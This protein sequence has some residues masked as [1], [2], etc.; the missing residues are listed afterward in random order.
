M[1]GSMTR[2]QVVKLI[3]ERWCKARGHEPVARFSRRALQR[4]EHEATRQELFRHRA[5]KPERPVRVR[6]KGTDPAADAQYDAAYREYAPRFREWHAREDRLMGLALAYPYEIGYSYDC[7]LGTI[8]HV[9][10]YG[11]SWDEACEK[12]GLIPKRETVNA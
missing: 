6:P 4:E 10:G 1:E 11:F 7:V 5:Q 12:A 9:S 2:A 8:C 3:R